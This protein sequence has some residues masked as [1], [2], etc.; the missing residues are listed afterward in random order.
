[1]RRS[2]KEITSSTEIEE[3]IQKAVVCHLGLIDGDEPYIVPMSFG[4][5]DKTLYLHSATEGRK[6]DVIKKNDNVCFELETDIEMVKA[7]SACKWSTK[8]RSVMGTGKAK[9]IEDSKAK[10][11]GLS[12]IAAHYAGIQYGFQQ[13]NVDKV[14]VIKIDIEKLSGKKSKV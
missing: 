4:Y 5:Q 10:A 14:L 7:E 1:M 9:I 8:Y 2:E 3:I 6:I 11:L 12:I 13:E